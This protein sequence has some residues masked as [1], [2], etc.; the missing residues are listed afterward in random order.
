MIALMA[1]ALFAQTSVSINI[2]S[3]AKDSATAAHTD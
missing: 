1:V 3:K 2:G